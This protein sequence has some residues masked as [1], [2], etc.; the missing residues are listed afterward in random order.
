[1]NKEMETEIKIGRNDDCVEEETA[2]KTEE[3]KDIE[4]MYATKEWYG[5][6]SENY[7]HVNPNTE[8]NKHNDNS[9]VGGLFEHTGAQKVLDEL[10]AVLCHLSLAISS[11][12]YFNFPDL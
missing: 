6:L 10:T 12:S 8:P 2:T 7:I 9:T 1:M 5:S 4:I 3:D 11:T